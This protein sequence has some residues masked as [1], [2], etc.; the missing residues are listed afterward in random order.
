[1]DLQTKQIISQIIAFL[2]T[3]WILKRFAWKPILHVLEERRQHI[4]AEF[5]GIQ[6]QKADIEQLKADYASKLKGI[7]AEARN[8]LQKAVNEGRKISQDIQQTARQQSQEIINK[9]KDEIKEEVA[10][11]KIQLKNDVVNLTMQAT[12]KILRSSIDPG[13]QK[14]LV[15]EFIKESDFK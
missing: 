1:M 2:I 5:T 15:Q 11:A 6:Q 8:Q 14:A 10:K 3:L 7:D 9:A 12:D 13:K 4:K